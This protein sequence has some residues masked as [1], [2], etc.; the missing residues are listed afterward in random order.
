MNSRP[1]VVFLHGVGT[2]ASS[3]ALQLRHFSNTCECIAWD[4]PGYGG[5]ASWDYETL[6]DLPDYLAQSVGGFDLEPVHWVGHSLGGMLAQEIA[7]QHPEWVRSLTL[8]ATSPAFG[9]PDGEWQR[10]FLKQRLAPLQAGKTLADLAEDAISRMSAASANPEGRACA[11]QSMR[12]VPNAAYEQA[13]RALVA[14]DRR[15]HLSEIAAPT[16]L[17]A[18]EQDTNAPAGVMQRMASRIPGARFVT[19]E[20]TGHLVPLERP[21]RFNQELELF[22]GG[23]S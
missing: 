8:V 17:V 18:G 7:F 14:F 19:Y 23:L 3:W 10:E 15:A 9:R 11:L 22:W 12:Q 1:K 5:T 6:A 21:E 4:L 20:E 2:D 16:L 13:L